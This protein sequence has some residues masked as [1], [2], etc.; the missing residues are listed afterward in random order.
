[1]EWI[2]YRSRSVDELAPMVSSHRT[3]SNR[4]LFSRPEKAG[5]CFNALDWIGQFGG[6]KEE[7]IASVAAWIMSDSGGTRV[8]A[9]P[10]SVPR[11]CSC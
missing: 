7:D 5:D 4:D 8:C 2:P 1:M 9:R 11:P 10:S 6:T 3:G